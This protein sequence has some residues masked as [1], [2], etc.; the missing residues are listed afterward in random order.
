MGVFVYVQIIIVPKLTLLLNSKYKSIIIRMLVLYNKYHIPQRLNQ[1][2]KSLIFI[3]SL[4]M[5]LK[6]Q[7]KLT[8][9]IFMKCLP[10]TLLKRN[11]QNILKDINQY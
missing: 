10:G 1:E 2:M 8:H 7:I 9:K 11:V 6:I 4:V 5:N 3:Y